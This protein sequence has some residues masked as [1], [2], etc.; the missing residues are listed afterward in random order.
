LP[1]PRREEPLRAYYRRK[2][3][4]RSFSTCAT[5]RTRYTAISG[6]RL[7]GIQDLQLTELATRDFSRS[8]KRSLLTTVTALSLK[9]EIRFFDTKKEADKKKKH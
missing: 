2:E 4:Q 3:V 9:G 6:I 1:A 7:A 5:T 8:S